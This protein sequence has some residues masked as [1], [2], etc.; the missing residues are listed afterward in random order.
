MLIWPIT[1]D[2]WLPR[3]QVRELRNRWL[4][5]LLEKFEIRQVVAGFEP[6]VGI[7]TN[8]GQVYR[9]E[10]A[11]S[12]FILLSAFEAASWNCCED[13]L[14][15]SAFYKEENRTGYQRLKFPSSSLTGCNHIRNRQMLIS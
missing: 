8:T 4:S 13:S 6:H 3:I 2:Q 11:N 14:Y 12:Y 9:E 15:I 10:R 5:V 7:F 1:D